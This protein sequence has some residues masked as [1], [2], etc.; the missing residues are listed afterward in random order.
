M[1]FDES[2][3]GAELELAEPKVEHAVAMEIDFSPIVRLDEPVAL[4]GK[5]LSDAAV[6]QRL[7]NLD[8]SPM[9][10]DVIFEL[11]PHRVERVADGNQ[12]I[13]ISLVIHDEFPAWYGEVE[14]HLE[15]AATMMM[16]DWGFNH[17]ATAYDAVVI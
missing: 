2:Y 14:T 13:F 7:V 6:G 4:V 15:R 5:E 9:L 17:H 11:A 3:L 12:E 8:V 1:L 16:T 10:A